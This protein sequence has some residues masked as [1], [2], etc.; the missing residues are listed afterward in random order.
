MIPV[1]TCPGYILYIPLNSF[2]KNAGKRFEIGYVVI[3]YSQQS[4]KYQNIKIGDQKYNKAW[5]EHG[6]SFF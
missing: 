3:K 5:I 2:N 4:I 1:E 6:S